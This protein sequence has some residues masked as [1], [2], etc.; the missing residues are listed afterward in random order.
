MLTFPEKYR[1]QLAPPWPQT[2]EGENGVFV[3]NSPWGPVR[4]I[5]ASGDGWDHVS[6]SHPDK[7]PNWEIMC[8]VKAMFFG[9]SRTAMQ[10]H[11]P[12]VDYV[13]CHQFV[14]HLWAPLEG[15]IPRPPNWMV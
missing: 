8:R 6:V 4:C 1:I 14:L 15:E 2:V 9:G 11:P 13:N 3:F 5:A 12:E 10:L 7:I